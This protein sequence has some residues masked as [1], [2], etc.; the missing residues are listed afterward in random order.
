V[1]AKKRKVAEGGITN[2]SITCVTPRRAREEAL[3]LRAGRAHERAMDWHTRR[4]V[5]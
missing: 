4:P 2:T 3:L 1:S 5:L